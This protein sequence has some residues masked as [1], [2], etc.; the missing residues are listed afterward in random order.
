M[1][2]RIQ[3]IK[4]FSSTKVV[5]IDIPQ[6]ILKKGDVGIKEYLE[7]SNEFALEKTRAF[8][9]TAVKG[10]NEDEETIEIL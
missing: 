9:H 1:N 5:S 10:L 7:T 8:C 6:H 3:I 4:Y 2:I